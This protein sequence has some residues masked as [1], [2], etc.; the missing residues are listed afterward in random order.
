MDFD[1]L[2]AAAVLMVLVLLILV[3]F[4]QRAWDREE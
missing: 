2:A 1:K 4:L 3:R